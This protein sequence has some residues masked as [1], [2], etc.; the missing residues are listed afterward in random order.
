[1]D[2]NTCVVL[3]D[4]AGLRAIA[5][6]SHLVPAAIAVFLGW[7][8]ATRAKHSK[9]SVA[10]LFFTVAV[11][12][13]LIGDV[14]LWTARDYYHVAFFWSWLDFVDVV[15]FVL[16]AFFFGV[17][18]RGE[19]SRT[20]KLLLLALCI[21]AFLFTVTGNSVTEFHQV[22]CEM[23]NNES[24]VLYKSF[25]EW[26]SLFLMFLSLALAWRTVDR[27]RKTALSIIFVALV[28]FLM[29]FSVTEYFAAQTA[30]YEI[31]L[32][33]L[34]AL[35]VF[36]IVMVFAITNLEV[37]KIRY[38]GTQVLIYVLIL[39]VASQFL[40]LQSST[41]ALLNGLTL[42]LAVV[43][44]AILLQNEKQELN[45]LLEIEELAGELSVANTR[46]HELDHMKSQFLSFA[47]HQ[48]KAPITSVKWTASLI[49]DGSLGKVP[50]EVAKAA[51]EM[52]D[53][54]DELV[55]LI[56][57]FLDLR[58]LEEGRMDYRFEPVD[59]AAMAA[60][61]VRKLEPSAHHK[62]LELTL[63]STASHSWAMA[64]LQKF[65]QV[66]TNLIDNAIK[67]TEKGSV[68]VTATNDDEKSVTISVSDTGHGIDPTLLPT[69]FEEFNRDRKEA[70]R[71]EGT[72]LGLYI[73]KQIVGAHNGRIWAESPGRDKGSTF[74]AL[75][76]TT[77]Q[78]P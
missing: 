47:S 37:F 12:L 64:D 21:P 19:V 71:I 35:P 41:D 15:F 43:I 18:A 24:S 4:A 68:T 38:L 42:G 56:N 33:G 45:S 13:W 16:A 2:L 49:A 70:K 46:L 44:G 9:S 72:G 65:S 28:L 27:R 31:N 17:L 55:G 22:W 63:R 20:E 23:G 25:A 53:T 51:Q 57:E 39:L 69:L 62:G 8:V 54:V 6:Y 50:P 48:L 32:Y 1:M 58:K 34:F 67:Y 10:F 78:R 26:A 77:T 7:Y 36:L 40:F 59:I 3:G 11:A 52:E 5:Y 61:I 60:D 74:R 75:I 73:A 76:P 29:T 66:I 30:V 14:F